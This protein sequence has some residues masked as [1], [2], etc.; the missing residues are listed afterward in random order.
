MLRGLQ[1]D[2]LVEDAERNNGKDQPYFMDE[3]LLDVMNFKNETD[4]PDHPS[5]P[6]EA[7]VLVDE[8]L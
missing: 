6:E 3:E 7:A 4:A 8:E 1:N 2:V 5:A